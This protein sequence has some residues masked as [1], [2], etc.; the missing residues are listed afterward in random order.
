[1]LVATS[2]NLE[3]PVSLAFKGQSSSGKSNLADMVLRFIP[4]SDVYLS[5]TL[6]NTALVYSNED[7]RHRIIVVPELAGLGF[8]DNQGFLNLREFMSRN[9]LIHTATQD[10]PKGG[11]VAPRIEK[12]GPISVITTTTHLNIFEDLDTRLIVVNVDESEEH[13]KLVAKRSRQTKRMQVGQEWLSLQQWLDLKRQLNGPFRVDVPFREAMV[14]MMPPAAF[15]Q[16][17]IIRDIDHFIGLVEAHAVLHHINR[18]I[19]PNGE[20]IANMDDYIVVRQLMN[21]V[22]GETL[23]LTVPDGIRKVVD[24]VEKLAPNPAMATG[25]LQIANFLSADIKTIRRHV[26]IAVKLGYLK[27]EMDYKTKKLHLSRDSNCLALPMYL[28]VLPRPD[29]LGRYFT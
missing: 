10:A 22:L 25:I 7:F 16:T 8:E 23:H 15:K 18:G 29:V 20:Y 1:M 13:I 6:S 4:T 12:E 24:A 14:D 19:S 28:D 9:K 2:R 11:R 26:S 17:R 5:T 3:D 21:D 27:G